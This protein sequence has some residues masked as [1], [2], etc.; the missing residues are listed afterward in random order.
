MQESFHDAGLFMSVTNFSTTLNTLT[1]K[2][3]YT[4]DT[5]D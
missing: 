2:W 1:S 3:L 5:H 4:F